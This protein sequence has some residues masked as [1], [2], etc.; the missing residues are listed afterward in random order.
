MAIL[1]K[2]TDKCSVKCQKN[3]LIFLNLKSF[4]DIYA[5]FV[6][7]NLRSKNEGLEIEKIQIILQD[8]LDLISNIFQIS[9][10]LKVPNMET[11]SF[12]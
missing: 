12:K 8:Y 5:L 1:Q 10:L 2:S 7:K 4:R 6:R 9:L 3:I 11:P